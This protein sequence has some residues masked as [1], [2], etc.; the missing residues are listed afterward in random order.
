MLCD[1]TKLTRK[2]CSNIQRFSKV[3]VLIYCTNH[4]ME[5]DLHFGLSP[6]DYMLLVIYVDRRAMALG[7]FRWLEDVSLAYCV[8]VK[9][10][11]GIFVYTHCML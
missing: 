2:N 3:K 7:P 1:S 11:I 4:C 10:M 8:R 5:F 6:S 9:V